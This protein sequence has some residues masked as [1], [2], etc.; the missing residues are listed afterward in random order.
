MNSLYLVSLYTDL[1]RF[2]CFVF[3]RHETIRSKME[4]ILKLLIEIAK[5]QRMMIRWLIPNCYWEH[6]TIHLCLYQNSVMEVSKMI[7]HVKICNRYG[8]EYSCARDFYYIFLFKLYIV[9]NIWRLNLQHGK[10][11]TLVEGSVLHTWV[12]VG[13][14]KGNEMYFR[15]REQYSKI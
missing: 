3:A 15:Q 14:Q 7:D 13:K 8:Y 5:K 11:D 4:P 10:W 6:C 1:W 9:N 12:E 2:F